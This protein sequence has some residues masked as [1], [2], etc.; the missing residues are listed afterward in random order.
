MTATLR[1]QLFQE[2]LM[3]RE[4]VYA[5][6]QPTP[7]EPLQLPVEAEVFVK[8]EDVSP[9][10]SYKWR[11]AYNRMAMLPEEERAA[12]VVAASAGNHA[13]GV[14]VAARALGVQARIYMP[15]S[16][17]RRK[18]SAVTRHGQNRV[19]LILHADNYHAPAALAFPDV[20]EPGATFIH[21]YDDLRTMGGQGTLADEVVM[22]GHGPFDTAYVQIGGGGL[23]AAVSC[24]LK[25]Y[26]PE[27][28]IVGVEG[29]NQA[30]MAAAIQAGGP[31]EP[32]YV[33]VFC[34]GT[35]VKK[36]GDP[37]YAL[38]SELIDEFITVT[39]E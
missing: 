39:N 13:Q 16:A 10:H 8:R 31:V 9:V 15:A 12:G 26:Y 21:P 35:A 30:S 1:E 20:A 36:V 4:R 2:I 38:C 22:S 11:G 29:V 28:R 7:I 5:V 27:I 19:E 24:W 18:Q 33:D 17:P 25:A 32:D 23:A 6:G 14:A 37:T 3:A 34:D